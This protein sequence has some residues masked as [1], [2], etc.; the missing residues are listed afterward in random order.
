MFTEKIVWACLGLLVAFL[1]PFGQ[2]NLKIAAKRIDTGSISAGL[3][4]ILLNKNLY[5]V[6]FLY[7]FATICYV[8]LLRNYELSRVSIFLFLANC[9][10]PIVS[11]LVLGEGVNILYIIGLSMAMLGMFVIFLSM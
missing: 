1:I 11:I 10:T 6:F 7:L 5:F 8:Y 2:I 4:S 3:Q 9:L